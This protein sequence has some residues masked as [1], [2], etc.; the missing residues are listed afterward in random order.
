MLMIGDGRRLHR[1]GV[2]HLHH[3]P[4]DTGGEK[5]KGER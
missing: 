4:A 5:Q 2:H 3:A 1:T